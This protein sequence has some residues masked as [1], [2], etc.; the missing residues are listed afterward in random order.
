V[1]ISDFKNIKL[2]LAIFVVAV[3]WGTTF[4][5]IKI[6]VQTIPPWFVAGMR[7]FL[8]GFILFI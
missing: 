7:P 4:I 3:V 5:G 6:A 2:L 1:K 8:A